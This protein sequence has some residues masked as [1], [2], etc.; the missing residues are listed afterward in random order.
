MISSQQQLWPS[1]KTTMNL[2]G[3]EQSER[4]REREEKKE[5]FNDNEY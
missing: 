2:V 1:M 5:N 4:E 3:I